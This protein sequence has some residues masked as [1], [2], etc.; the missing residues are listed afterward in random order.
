MKD[1]DNFLGEL[2]E[3]AKGAAAAFT[4]QATKIYDASKQKVSAEN[5]KRNIGKKL[6][7]LG[8]LTY[9]A[10][11]QE[12]DLSEDIAAVVAEI[13]ELKQSLKQVDEQL[14][15]LM[16]QKICPD[17]GA[18]LSM[19]S[20]FCNLCGHK[21]EIPEEPIPAEAEEVTEA[22]EEAVETTEEA[23]VVNPEDIVVAAQEA[24]EEISE[25]ADEVL[26]D[27]DEAEKK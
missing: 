3:N 15:A 5:I 13:S 9:K 22:A 23:P 18:K 11:T 27:A 2:L 4:Q 24:A 10:T 7:E 26:A 19:E 25:E 14:A 21:F 17:C 12:V 16:N 1:F 8:K 6:I 20:V